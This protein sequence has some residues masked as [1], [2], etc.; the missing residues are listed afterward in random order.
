MEDHA[1]ILDYLPLGYVREGAPSFK[2][3]PIA[4]AVGTEE[5]TLLELIPKE[6]VQLDI[7]ERVYIGPGKRDEIARVNSRLKYEKLTATARVELDYVIA[8]II[9]EKEDKFIEFFNEAGPISTRLHQ[10]ELLP[11]IGKKHMWDIIN[12]RKEAKFMS[13][14]DIKDRVSML[15]EPVKLIA[16]RVHLELEAG[17]DRKGKMKYIL[18]T[19]PPKPK[20]HK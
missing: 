11:G 17:E 7:H 5:F 19:R 2:R 1:I 14:E 9:K 3:K 18:F 4:Q 13:F 6:Q 8:E 10:L 12:A 16:K 15:A 20:K